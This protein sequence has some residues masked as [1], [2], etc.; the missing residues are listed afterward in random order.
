MSKTRRIAFGRAKIED[1]YGLLRA[2]RVGSFCFPA[3]E[4]G[5]TCCATRQHNRRTSNINYATCK[6]QSVQIRMET[7]C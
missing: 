6:I 5:E 7:V 4:W 3:Y 1:V 2:E